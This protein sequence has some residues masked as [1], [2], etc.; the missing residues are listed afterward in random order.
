MP[1]VKLPLV[2]PPRIGADLAY[3]AFTERT[4]RPS[5]A[6]IEAALGASLPLWDE[7]ILFVATI[8][9]ARGELRFYGRN[10][11]WA[12]TFRNR[13]RSLLGLFPAEGEL[14]GLVVLNDAET[15]SALTTGLS[16]TV[17][18]VIAQTRPI[19]EGR[20]IYVAVRDHA[21]VEDV[22]RLVAARAAR[23]A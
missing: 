18:E 4:D 17:L 3:G 14:T 6:A 13:G 15:Q 7:L 23:P 16:P 1:L 22:K 11:G 19:K 5:E 10:H 20:W 12:L 9:R 2:T 21:A 8:T